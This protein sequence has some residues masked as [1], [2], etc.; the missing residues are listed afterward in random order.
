VV[1]DVVQHHEITGRDSHA[2]AIRRYEQA[3]CD[4][5]SAEV[6]ESFGFPAIS[7]AGSSTVYS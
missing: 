1:A 7:V 2:G 3:V 5:Q 4:G 6:A